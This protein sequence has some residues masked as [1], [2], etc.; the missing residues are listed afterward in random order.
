MAQE[1]RLAALRKP[2]NCLYNLPMLIIC[3]E[4]DLV[5]RLPPTHGTALCARCGGVLHE[6]KPNSIEW[7]LALSLAGLVLFA[8]SNAFPL[9]LFKIQ[10]DM[11][12]ATLVGGVWQLFIEGEVALAG[13]VLVTTI[14][15]PLLRLLLLVYLFAPLYF[16]WPLPPGL[17]W[18][19]KLN[20]SLLPWSMMEVFMLGILVSIVKLMGMAS[21]VPGIALWSFAA[22]IILMAEIRSVCD[23]E[24]AWQ[25]LETSQ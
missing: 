6:P 18:A 5:N 14:A 15:A 7:T 12:Y 8:L 3:H 20:Q 21:I 4:C 11:T 1:R 2:A 16:H 23:P 17:A 22:L 13:L 10:G 9:L 25:R 19:L 24:L